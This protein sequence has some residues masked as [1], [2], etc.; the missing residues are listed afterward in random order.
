MKG[1]NDNSDKAEKSKLVNQ[2]VAFGELFASVPSLKKGDILN[3]DWVPGTGLQSFLNG[4]QVGQT[5]AEP[6]FFNA[7]LKIWL[8]D[9]TVD[10][11][12]KEKMLGEK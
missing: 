8:G 2:T 3:L 7:V 9:R 4:K 5:I 12:L 10:S 1:L 11:S 6:L